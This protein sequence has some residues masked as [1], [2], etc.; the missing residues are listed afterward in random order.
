M[1]PVITMTTI[2]GATEAK[3]VG[4]RDGQDEAASAITD[5]CPSSATR[6]N[7]RGSKR[8]FD[9]NITP[10]SGF[11]PFDSLCTGIVYRF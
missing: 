5:M 2:A 10:F 8:R 6:A 1:Q 7:P 9:D 11:S 3:S 4:S